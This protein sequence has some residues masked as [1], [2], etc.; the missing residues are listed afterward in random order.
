MR[1]DALTAELVLAAYSQGVFPMAHPEEDNAIYW[2]APDPRA[3]LPLDSFHVPSNV[4]KLLR[5]RTFEVTFDRSFDRVIRACA[6]R[7]ETWISPEIISVYEQLH[8]SGYAHSVEVWA[9]AEL[10]GGLYGVALGGAFF[11]ES[12]F[13]RRSGASMIALV[14]LVEQMRRSGFALLDTQFS[15][16]HLARFGVRE[17]PRAIYEQ[18]LIAALAIETLW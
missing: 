12:M 3:I 10:A 6:D 14:A 1:R 7:E 15:T 5:R 2:Y 16:P 13:Y 9:D 4:R 8:R 18:K 11:G 17:I